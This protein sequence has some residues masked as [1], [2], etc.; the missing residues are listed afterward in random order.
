MLASGVETT[1]EPGDFFESPPG[2]DTL[3][4]GDDQVEL[5]LFALPDRPH[6]VVAPRQVRSVFPPNCRH[7]MPCGGDLKVDMQL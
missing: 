7:A 2:H 6:K 3:I 5:I 4:G 1:I